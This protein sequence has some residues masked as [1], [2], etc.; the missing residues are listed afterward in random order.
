VEELGMVTELLVVEADAADFAEV[1]DVTD[2]VDKLFSMVFETV[3]GTDSYASVDE[4]APPV[5]VRF[6][7]EYP[8]TSDTSA[9]G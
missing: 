2:K 8:Y 3:C 9:L 7:S 1:V 5:V 4:E 6:T